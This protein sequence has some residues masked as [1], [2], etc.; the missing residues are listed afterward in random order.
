MKIGVLTIGAEL[1]NGSRL[2]TNAH[3]IAKNV[4]QYNGEVIL[5]KTTLDSEESI[6]L[7]LDHFLNSPVEMILI[8]GGLGPTHDDITASSLY[9]Y[10]NDE[11]VFDSFYWEKLKKRFIKRGFEVSNLSKSQAFIPSDG[12]AI[13]NKLGTARGLCFN[14]GKIKIIAMPGVPSEMK[15]MMSETVLP[16]IKKSSNTSINYKNLRTTGISESKLFN[17]LKDIINN[18]SEVDIAFLPSYLGVDIRV[19]SKKTSLFESV[20]NDISANIYNFIYSSD[21]ESLEE[22]VSNILINNKIT[23]STAESCTGGRIADRLTNV[24]GISSVYF[25]GVIA[26]SNEQKINLL[27]VKEEILNEHGAVSEE[28]AIS[29]AIG[30]RKKFTT[31]IGISTTGI[32]GPG[33]GTSKKPVGLVYIGLAYNDILKAYKFNFNHDRISN[34]MITSQVALNILRNNLLNQINN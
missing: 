31:D 33:G 16:M 25:G 12:E 17:S 14:S 18:N 8:T 34:K 1:L 10:F 27:N 26:Y 11:P 6:V 9:K 7:A 2:D 32:A 13:P 19:T 5:K 30:I 21:E 22:V 15:S 28:T 23:I 24:S 20:L 29:M 4:I 3:W